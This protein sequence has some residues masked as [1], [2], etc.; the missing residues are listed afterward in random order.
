MLGA[1][2]AVALAAVT[3]LA[4][5]LAAVAAAATP[6]WQPVAKLPTIVDVAGPRADGQLV[7]SSRSGLFLLGSSGSSTGPTQ[8][9]SGPGGYTASSGEP[10]IALAP[11]RRIAADRCSFHRDDVYAIDG[12]STPGIVRILSDGRATRFADFEAG[13]FPSGIAFDLVGS[14][15]YRLLVTTN[16]QEGGKTTVYAFDC[17]G[18]AT[19]VARDAPHVEGGIA[20]A[21]PSF[22]RFGRDLIAVNEDDGN[23]YA[24]TPHGAVRVVAK[25][26]LR[27]GGD[28]G[29]ESVGFVPAGFDARGTAYMSDLGSPGAPTPGDDSLLA[30]H[31]LTGVA[32]GDLLVATE[33][34][35]TTIA[36]RC[37]SRC[38]VKH[39]A[40]GPPTTHG[41]G[42]IVFVPA[43]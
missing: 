19:V 16:A 15:G 22:G 8:F 30:L 33:A 10:Y 3:A 34:G 25:S 24:F 38:T 29:V 4:G 27:A 14:F 9:A 31:G 28:I 12:D 11:A 43:A 21:P 36:V 2:R 6:V 7:L 23:V 39:V 1:R 17:L 37:A 42:H 20:V 41:E 40:D 18:R 35:A 13:V 26:G 32:P 5:C